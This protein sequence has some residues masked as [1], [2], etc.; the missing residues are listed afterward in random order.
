[1]AVARLAKQESTK[2]PSV[3]QL[4]E[5]HKPKAIAVM[6]A[7]KNARITWAMMATGD[8]LWEGEFAA[9]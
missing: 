7:N 5:R 9:A 3:A 4:L 6:L 2:W 8:A 1:M